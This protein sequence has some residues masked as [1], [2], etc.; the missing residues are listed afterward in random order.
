MTPRERRALIG[1]LASV[2]PSGWRGTTA[3][4]DIEPGELSFMAHQSVSIRKL[5][6]GTVRVR[7]THRDPGP[8]GEATR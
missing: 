4:R 1:A 6:D 3:Y 2:H 7:V 8:V 5:R